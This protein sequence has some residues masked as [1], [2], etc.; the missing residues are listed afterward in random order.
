MEQTTTALIKLNC[1]TESEIEEQ[2]EVRYFI[3]GMAFM[4]PTVECL[5]DV[6]RWMTV[7]H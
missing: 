1:W 4:A 7:D 3:Q 5:M 6:H 2:A